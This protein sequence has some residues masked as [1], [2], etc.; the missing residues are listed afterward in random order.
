MLFLVCHLQILLTTRSRRPTKTL[1]PAGFQEVLVKRN[2]PYLH[3]PVGWD[4]FPC[5][6]ERISCKSSYESDTRLWQ[7]ALYLWDRS[8][9]HSE[10]RFA[11]HLCVTFYFLEGVDSHGTRHI[12]TGSKA[13]PSLL[14][15][16]QF[17]DQRTCSESCPRRSGK[18]NT[19][20]RINLFLEHKSMQSWDFQPVIL[21]HPCAKYSDKQERRPAKRPR[22][23][24]AAKHQ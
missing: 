5:N 24:C 4:V 16:G 7:E 18:T 2:T 20:E 10:V 12:L 17:R 6:F 23:S 19:T 22:F 15:V 11:V 3:S 9:F 8:S 21:A 14:G 13:L 1:D